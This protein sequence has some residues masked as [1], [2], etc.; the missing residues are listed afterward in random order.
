MLSPILGSEA[1]YQQAGW[2]TPTL[3][4]GND[5]THG[6]SESDN[7]KGIRQFL[8]VNVANQSYTSLYTSHSIEMG[9]LAVGEKG[10]GTN[11]QP[12][13]GVFADGLGTVRAAG[14]SAS[15]DGEIKVAQHSVTQLEIVLLYQSLEKR[16]TY[17]ASQ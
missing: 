5:Y 7:D 6:T 10:D 1:L 14:A 16:I 17:E 4:A 15:I 2:M 8:D 12:S 13:R 3:T 11:K 9:P